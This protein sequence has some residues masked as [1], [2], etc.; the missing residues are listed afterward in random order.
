MSTQKSPQ[1]QLARESENA[2][3]RF[4]EDDHGWNVIIPGQQD[5]FGT[6]GQILVFEEGNHNQQKLEFQLKSTEATSNEVSI[7]MRHVDMWKNNTV[8]FFLFFWNKSENQIYFLNL[9]EYYDM[10]FRTNPEKLKQKSILLK[11]SEKLDNNSF[12]YIK[13][14]VDQF[15]DIVMQAIHE[16]QNKIAQIKDFLG[17][18]NV[19]AMGYSFA[20]NNIPKQV[21]RGAAL[22][23]ANFE[24]TILSNSDMR[25]ISAMG[26]NFNGANLR[27]S[28]LRSA[29]VMGAYFEN[30]D[31]QETKLEGAAFMGAFLSGADFR[32]A[33]FDELSLWSIGKAY[34]FEKAKYN[35][36]IMEKIKS[37]TKINNYSSGN[38]VFDT[39]IGASQ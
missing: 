8:P 29:S 39:G 31:M 5:D 30:A 14:T 36:G 34:D 17:Q 13:R 10:L 23:G 18:E 25:G 7:E 2:L 3:K 16:H 1:Q 24:K 38:A 11:F 21:L 28:D 22:M 15:T 4:F 33:S 12:E 6:D 35:D 20:G 27:G 32:E 26:A 19:V 9:H 37:L